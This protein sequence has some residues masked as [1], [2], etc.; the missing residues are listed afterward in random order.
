MIPVDIA[1]DVCESL[2]RSKDRGTLAPRCHAGVLRSATAGMV[3]RLLDGELEGAVRPWD[4]P[5]LRQRSAALSAV[6]GARVVAA[7]D[8]V[9]VAE[10][11]PG[12]ERLV[13][14][15]VD[16]GWRLVRFADGT[17]YTVRPETSRR[18]T[19]RGGGP[20]AVL[21]ALGVV[22]PH[23]VEA[24]CVILDLDLDL[25][26]GQTQT[27]HRYQWTEG[28]RSVLAEEVT[29]EIFD[30][31]TPRS[32]SVRGVIVDGDGGV[33][34]SGSDGDAIVTQG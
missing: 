8:T 29:T 31:A 19:L 10:L 34:L 15:G 28:T 3:R 9:L 16:D 25:G 5:A 11:V 18:V 22:K 14:R 7:D 13:F 30:G 20:D 21:N 33:M 24:E 6:A 23:D 1:P 17:D 4:L 2:R 26:Q 27:R 32:T 12:G